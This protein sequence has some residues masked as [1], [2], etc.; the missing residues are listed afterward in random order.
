MAYSISSTYWTG[1]DKTGHG[2]VHYEVL[3]YISTKL[4]RSMVKKSLDLL[5]PV[6]DNN[7]T[8]S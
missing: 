7:S 3:K 1:G 2:G 5:N 8:C 4:S 6:K